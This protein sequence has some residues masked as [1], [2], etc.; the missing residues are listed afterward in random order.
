VDSQN[1]VGRDNELGQLD[2]ALAALDEDV[3]GCITLEGEPGIGKSRLLAELRA[4][5]DQ[6]GFAVL[7]GVAAEFER[8][9]PFSVWI[10]ALDP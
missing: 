4:R 9:R 8:D 5:A 6:R 10:D 2:V 1:L 7:S 3:G